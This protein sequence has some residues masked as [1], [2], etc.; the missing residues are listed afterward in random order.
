MDLKHGLSF[1]A[2]AKKESSEAP[3]GSV[4]LTADGGGWLFS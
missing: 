2:S 3:V 1:E 4:G